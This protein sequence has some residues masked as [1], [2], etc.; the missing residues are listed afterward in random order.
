MM[1]VLRPAGTAVAH[2]ESA[3]GFAF[4]AIDRDGRIMSANNA[5]CRL[6]GY[7]DGALNGMDVA[8]LAPEMRREG[9][10][11]D[12]ARLWSTL[13]E[14]RETRTLSVW[15]AR[16]N[17]G[18]FP[19]EVYAS[20]WDSEAG[21]AIAAI[22]R[23]VSARRSRK[24]RIARRD[25]LTGLP[26]RKRL[27]EKLTALVGEKASVSVILLGLEGLKKVNDDL[28]TKAGDS[29]LRGLAIRLPGLA[30]TNA[31]LA[32]SARSQFAMVLPGIGDPVQARRIANALVEAVNEPFSIAEH[33]VRLV[34]SAGIAMSPYAGSTAADLI[35]AAELAL[36]KAAGRDGSVALFEAAMRG[37][38][39]AQQAMNEEIVHAVEGQELE[40]HF[41]PQVDMESGA[42]VGGEALLRWRHS[43]RGILAPATFLAALESHSLAPEVGEW[44]LDEACRNA[45]R[46]RRFGTEARVSVNLFAGQLRGDDL[47]DVVAATLRRHALPPESLELEFTEA[48]VLNAGR[49]VEQQMA[50]LRALGV[51]IAFDDFGAGAASLSLLKRLPVT[52]LKLDRQIISSL[53]EDRYS[54]A[55]VP[56]MLQM[57]GA[58]GIKVAAVGVENG[59]QASRLMELGCAIGQGYHFARPMPAQ[60]FE[61]L[62]QKPKKRAKSA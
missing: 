25:P 42:I 10:Q 19:L 47:A 24:D 35:D 39:A 26:N 17:G 33:S 50:A 30:P 27:V 62:I 48:A 49:R 31:V 43:E 9:Y 7:A 14:P 37:S 54:E 34:G 51:G 21:P 2:G 12:F 1:T 58:L 28:G 29:V 11:L 16:A 36:H 53:P 13:R 32:R 41:Q 61:Q 56:A 20:G 55:V 45:A 23:D 22:V 60:R 6:F 4:V 8:A 57:C 44:I 40:L 59:A 46:W 18:Q 5:C 15:G 38:M 3:S 52:T